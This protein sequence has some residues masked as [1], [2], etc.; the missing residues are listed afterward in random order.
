MLGDIDVVLLW[1]DG[2]DPAWRQEFSRYVT[3]EEGDKSEAR[4][5]DWDNLQYMFRSFENC[6]PWVRKI[7]FVTWGHVPAWLNVG[8]PKLNIVNHRDILSKHNLPVFNSRAI[9][10]NIH[11]INGLAD[12]FIYFND[13]MFVL[14]KLRPEYFF[15]KERPRDLFALNI[16]STDIT[17]HMKINNIKILNKHFNKKKVMF[18]NF[19]K[20][21]SFRNGIEFIKSILLLPWPQFTGL[22]SHHLPQPFLK[23]TFEKVWS[24]EK[25][26]LELTSSSRFKKSSDVNQFLFKWWQILE[27]GF[28]PK[29]YSRAKKISLWTKEDVKEAAGLIYNNKLEVICLNDHLSDGSF[30]RI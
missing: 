6:T 21:F 4:F 18:D 20:W 3:L 29:S 19:A 23:S 7:H 27:G 8:H 26:I 5:R 24:L 17:A 12:K 10:C 1:V 15:I 2:D 9:E 14:R 22:Y 28:V 16:I 30:R 25:E 13:D 11:R